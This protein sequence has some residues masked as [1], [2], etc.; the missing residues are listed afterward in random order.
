MR[1]ERKEGR[2]AEMIEGASTVMIAIEKPSSPVPTSSAA[3]PGR[4]RMIVPVTIAR[5]DRPTMRLRPRRF[6]SHGAIGAAMSVRASGTLV[7]RETNVS[8]CP[9]SSIMR[10]TSGD[11]EIV[12]IRRLRPTRRTAAMARTSAASGRGG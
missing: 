4:E 2:S 1:R 8:A 12:G 5:R 10:G 9:V 11:R 6:A 3:S 7:S